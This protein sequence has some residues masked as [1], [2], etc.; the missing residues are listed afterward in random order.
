MIHPNQEEIMIR[1]LDNG[2][3]LCASIYL[4]QEFHD[5]KSG[6]DILYKGHCG[7]FRTPLNS[8]FLPHT[9]MLTGYGI[10]SAGEKYWRFKNSWGDKW[11]DRGF[12]KILRGPTAYNPRTCSFQLNLLATV[13][14]CGPIQLK[15][16]KSFA[17]K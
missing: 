11:A 15:T 12:G 7:E 16:V 3:C 5:I 4:F 14:E 8:D 9:V 2:I 10:T 17:G 6:Q 1:K 13:V